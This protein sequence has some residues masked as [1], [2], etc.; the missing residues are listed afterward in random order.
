MTSGTVYWISNVSTVVV[1]PSCGTVKS[2][3]VISVREGGTENVVHVKENKHAPSEMKSSGGREGQHV[4]TSA[5]AQ[6][7]P[8]IL[9]SG[10]SLV[11]FL[12]GGRCSVMS[13][14]GITVLM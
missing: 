5:F 4:M 14:G 13:K 1:F 7:L 2:E 9:Y 11:C 3:K 6:I 8:G 10:V 12:E